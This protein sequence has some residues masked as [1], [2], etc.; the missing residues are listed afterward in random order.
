MAFNP[1]LTTASS[2]FTRLAAYV[3]RLFDETTEHRP[4]DELTQQTP[5]DDRSSRGLNRHYDLAEFMSRTIA[6]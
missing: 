1:Y 2:G 4:I 5:P 3:E 6:P